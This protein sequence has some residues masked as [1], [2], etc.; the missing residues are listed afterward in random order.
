MKAFTQHRGVAAP[1]LR[2][3]IDTDTIIP[4]REMKRVSKQG[5]SDGLFA[6][7]RYSNP[8]ERVLNPDFILNQAS[9]ANSSILLGGDNFGCGSSREHAVWALM[10]Y[11][12]RCIIAPSFG[13]IFYQNC[14]R[15]GILPITL[16]D[17]IINNLAK[18]ISDD[19]QQCQLNI[20]LDQQQVTSPDGKTHSFPIEDSN[21]EMLLKGLDPIALTLTQEQ[22]INQFEKQDRLKRR[23]A[24]LD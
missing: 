8:D 9:Y 21:K 4:S 23:W 20:D 13:S 19:P 22:L 10:E 16:S 2:I 7:W 14:I 12:I 1:L 6:S 11:G 18:Q 24:Y 5:L 3:N 17:K 15:N